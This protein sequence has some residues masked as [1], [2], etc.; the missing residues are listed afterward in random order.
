MFV[1]F[2]FSY[3]SFFQL[4]QFE[5]ICKVCQENQSGKFTAY[6]RSWD[7]LFPRDASFSFETL[8]KENKKKHTHTQLIKAGAETDISPA[9][10]GDMEVVNSYLNFTEILFSPHL[11]DLVGGIF[12]LFPIY[13][14][15]SK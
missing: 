2:F 8:V 7:T 12:S 10:R 4:I 14:H 6:R 3:T 11:Q 5:C 9:H 15:C 1:F 13:S